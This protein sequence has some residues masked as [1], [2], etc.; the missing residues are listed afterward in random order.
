[1]KAP[2]AVWKQLHKN[3]I[4]KKKRNH[5]AVQRK[6]KKGVVVQKVGDFLYFFF[7][8]WP[9]PQQVKRGGQGEVQVKV[10]SPRFR[11]Q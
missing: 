7:H 5:W 6:G 3:K 2:V 8:S 11:F 1:M 9:A 10:K 4:R